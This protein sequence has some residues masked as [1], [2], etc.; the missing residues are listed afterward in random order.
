M[1][2]TKTFDT[3]KVLESATSTFLERGFD[4][5]SYE[6]LTRSVGLGRASLYNAFGDKE[7]LFC[8]CLEYFAKKELYTAMELLLDP[9][10]SLRDAIRGSF[11]SLVASSDPKKRQWGCLFVNTLFESTALRHKKIK[12]TVTGILD[13]FRNAFYDCLFRASKRGEA[14]EG[15]IDEVVEYLIFC[16]GGLRWYARLESS[17]PKLVQRI[18]QATESTLQLAQKK[19]I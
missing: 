11:I 18:D 4:G 7:A 10:T 19:N 12:S 14:S 3:N 13:P 8:Q 5:T 9:N 16:L 6:D 17:L 15:K 1:G 2:R